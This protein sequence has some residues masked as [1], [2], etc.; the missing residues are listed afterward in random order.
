MI[1]EDSENIHGE[2]DYNGEALKAAK[3][4]RANF[5]KW[6]TD[7]LKEIL[8]EIKHKPYLIGSELEEFAELTELGVNCTLKQTKKK[9]DQWMQ[10]E[11]RT[12][13]GTIVRKYKDFIPSDHKWGVQD[14]KQD[15]VVHVQVKVKDRTE[16][17]VI[18]LQRWEFL[19]A[20]YKKS[21][22]G[23]LTEVF[24]RLWQEKDARK[25]G[26]FVKSNSERPAKFKKSADEELKVE[27]KS[28]QPSTSH[29][30]TKKSH[31]RHQKNQ[32]DMPHSSVSHPVSDPALDP[33][34]PESVSHYIAEIGFPLSDVDPRL[35]KFA[36]LLAA[37]EYYSGV[38]MVEEALKE[39]RSQT[40]VR[41]EIVTP[42]E[43]VTL[44][45][46]PEVAA[47]MEIA[48]ESNTQEETITPQ[49]GTSQEIS[50]DRFVPN[51]QT[52]V[53]EEYGYSLTS[54]EF[55]SNENLDRFQGLDDSTRA[56]LISMSELKSKPRN[57]MAK[58]IH[59]VNEYLASLQSS[60]IDLP[61]F[62]AFCRHMKQAE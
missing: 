39:N 51:Q 21:D 16:N 26:T 29:S 41:K 9:V 46:M 52:S 31:S 14:R 23:R 47:E 62:I 61:S 25:A 58:F 18:S 33:N 11:R 60:T 40:P 49:A 17:Y 56:A 2:E 50:A 7:I 3:K 10:N 57:D 38:L 55:S 37:G 34:I 15:D 48:S 13:R 43:Q 42:S 28:P 5:E 1:S 6:Q 54:H 45:Q 36:T 27:P 30:K 24:R 19:T 8:M 4:T 44:E 35:R 32:L 59:T 22:P 20:E 53:L 12:D